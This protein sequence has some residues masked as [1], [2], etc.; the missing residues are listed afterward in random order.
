MILR[1]IKI[2]DSRRAKSAICTHFRGTEF[3]FFLN[4]CFFLKAE[5]YQINKIQSPI[6]YGV[7][8]T[9]GINGSFR[10][11]TFSETEKSSNLHTVYFWISEPK[12]DHNS[13][14]S[15]LFTISDMS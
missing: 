2:G 4:F 3:D 10:N 1:E 15:C 9:I 8:H 12:K 7:G 6:G 5:M 14:S 13:I 11:S